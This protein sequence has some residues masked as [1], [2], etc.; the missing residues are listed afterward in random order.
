MKALLLLLLAGAC[1]LAS[2]C[3]AQIVPPTTTG[4]R[5]PVVLASEEQDE[6]L[7]SH[8]EFKDLSNTEL[9]GPDV[10]G[11]KLGANLGERIYGG[12]VA[13]FRCNAVP[14][15]VSVASTSPLGTPES[16]NPAALT[17]RE[18]AAR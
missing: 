15:W 12:D 13:F 9:A 14:S 16:V 10:V 6:W 17:I 4:N 2:G 3:A 1:T 7:H 8:C 18:T 5:I 11:E